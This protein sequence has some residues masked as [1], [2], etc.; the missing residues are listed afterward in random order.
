MT[1][2]RDAQR[3]TLRPFRFWGCSRRSWDFI[4]L[5]NEIWCICIIMLGSPQDKSRNNAVIIYFNFGISAIINRL[6]ATQCCSSEGLETSLSSPGSQS[7]VA[8]LCHQLQPGT[9]AFRPSF[10]PP[11]IPASTNSKQK[12]KNFWTSW[13]SPCTP[14]ARCSCESSCRMHPTP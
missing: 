14:T 13:P 1:G 5:G 8:S 6:I 10:P 3:W 7:V 11:R 12:Q 2:A 4:W 9:C